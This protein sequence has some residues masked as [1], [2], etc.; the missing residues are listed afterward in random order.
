MPLP[1]LVLLDD[2]GLSLT[3]FASASDTSVLEALDSESGTISSE[4]WATGSTPSSSDDEEPEPPLQ[5][6]A[7]APLGCFLPMF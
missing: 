6:G 7:C 5:I 3:N 1:A 2:L 4:L